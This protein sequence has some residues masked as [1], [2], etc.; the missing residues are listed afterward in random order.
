LIGLILLLAVGAGL[1]ACK[2]GNPPTTTPTSG[3]PTQPPGFSTTKE[4]PNLGVTQTASSTPSPTPSYPTPTGTL[5]CTPAGTATLTPINPIPTVTPTPKQPLDLDAAQNATPWI[6]PD[7]DPTTGARGKAAYEKYLSVLNVLGKTYLTLLEILA[8][9]AYNEFGSTVRQDYLYSEEAL[10]RQLFQWCDSKGICV[11][12]RLWQFL[13]SLEGW[14]G[15]SADTLAANISNNAGI[16]TAKRIFTSSWQSGK[17]KTRPFVFGNT[18]M[19]PKT[20]RSIFDA[21]QGTTEKKSF[22][23]IEAL[24]YIVWSPEQKSYW[25][26]NE[27][28]HPTP[29]PE[30]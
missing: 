15:K 5:S 2:G 26:A 21:G 9:V 6:G 30:R 17:V 4:P 18:S 24:K 12:D 1:V 7:V 13:G 10:G 14:Y 3:P 25:Y 11:G 19:Y 29:T 8:T 27:H 28:P 20:E 23:V 16:K 22:V